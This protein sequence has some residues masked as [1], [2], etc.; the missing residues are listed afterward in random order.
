MTVDVTKILKDKETI[1]MVRKR[2]ESDTEFVINL[3][4]KLQ[5]ECPHP[6]VKTEEYYHEGG[7]DHLSSNRIVKTCTICEKIIESYN[8][9]NHRG[10]YA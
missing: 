10:S 4:R 3:L 6:T 7:Y 2:I 1:E 8:D 5:K 9:P